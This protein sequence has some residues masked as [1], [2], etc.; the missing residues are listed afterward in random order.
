[1]MA[2]RL[3]SGGAVRAHASVARSKKPQRLHKPVKGSVVASRISSRCMEAM[4]SAARNL[5]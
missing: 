5:A 3:P 2:D 1:M 4:R